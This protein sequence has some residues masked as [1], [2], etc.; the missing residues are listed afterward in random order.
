MVQV[1]VRPGLL[2]LEVLQ[3]RKSA[4][5][6]EIVL[7]PDLQDD[8]RILDLLTRQLLQLRAAARVHLRLVLSLLQAVLQ[9]VDQV[10]L[11]E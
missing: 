11:L 10:I 7:V 1:A 6:E 9:V 3:L 4:L 8:L 2:L 5:A